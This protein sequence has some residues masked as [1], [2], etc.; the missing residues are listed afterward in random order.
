MLANFGAGEDKGLVQED[1]LGGDGK[2][3]GAAMFWSGWGVE[4]TLE[5]ISKAGLDVRVRDVVVDWS[6]ASFLWVLAMKGEA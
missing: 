4:G 3:D 2:G 1:W 6:E 5:M